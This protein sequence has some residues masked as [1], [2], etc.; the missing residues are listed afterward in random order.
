MYDSYV[1]TSSCR[2]VVRRFQANYP[3]VRVPSRE[4]VR[5]LVKFRETGSILDKKRKSKKKKRKKNNE[6][7][8]RN[9]K[10]NREG[11]KEEEN[12]SEEMKIIRKETI[13]GP[14]EAK[15]GTTDKEFVEELEAKLNRLLDEKYRELEEE[16]GLTKGEPRQ[17]EGGVMEV[18]KME[19]G[20]REKVI[21]GTKEEGNQMGENKTERTKDWREWRRETTEKGAEVK[22][23]L[24]ERVKEKEENKKFK[25]KQDLIHDVRNSPIQCKVLS[26][27]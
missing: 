18:K 8:K 9:E 26:G 7:K 15:T 23:K 11:K 4:S 19:V 22:S 24:R 14:E 25:M 5:L 27:K 1:I 13:R 2:E 6:K 3:G 20:E 21:G 10:E 16:Y 17:K 12:K